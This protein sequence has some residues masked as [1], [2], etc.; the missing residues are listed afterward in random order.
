MLDVLDGLK[1][2]GIFAG[3]GKKHI[4]RDVSFT[5]AKGEL[6]SLIGPNGCGKSTLLKATVGILPISDGEILIDGRSQRTLS[7]VE[8][9]KKISY[10]AQ[11]KETP[12][13]T[14][15]QM[16]LHGRF[17]HLRYPRRYTEADRALA[18]SAIERM[19][20]LEL[21]N[22]PM[23]SLS[24]GMRQNAYLAMALTQSTEYLLLDEPT[25][26]LD[27]SHQ[28]ALMQTLRALSDEGRGVAVVTHDLPLAFTYSDRIIVMRKGEIAALGTPREVCASG[29]VREIFGIELSYDEEAREYRYRYRQT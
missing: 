20:L 24:G 15:E 23:A 4:L 16:V 27:V 25:T 2:K 10:L 21:A 18:A 6:I 14:V 3:Y 9:A 11:G 7:R 19:G 26:Y 8:I 22:E 13:M 29:I 5:L 28:L 12:D 1:L 17:P